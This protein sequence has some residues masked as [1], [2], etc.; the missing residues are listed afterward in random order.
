MKVFISWSG[1]RSKIIADVLRDW[2]PNVIQNVNPWTSSSDIDAG[3]RWP[4][5]LAEQLQQTNLGII[6]LTAENLKAPWILFEA[7]AL[8]KIMDK[9]KVCP[10]L[11]ALEPTEV[12]GPLAQFQAVKANKEGTKKLLQT[13]N[14]LQ[15]ES[16]LPEDRLNKSFEAFWPKLEEVLLEV[17]KDHEQ[18]DLVVMNREDS[19]LLKYLKESR[20]QYIHLE[21]RMATLGRQAKVE[22]NEEILKDMSISGSNLLDRIEQEK[23]VLSI[24]TSK[25]MGNTHPVIESRKSEY[26]H[27]LRLLRT[28][29][30]NLMI[31]QYRNRDEESRKYEIARGDALAARDLLSNALETALL[32]R[33]QRAIDDMVLR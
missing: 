28:A 32:Q 19:E 11:F 26:L 12:T 2:L 13:I 7:G 22:W 14:R 18:R 33:S 16:A 10:Y 1:S 5:A 24:Y 4:L 21:A 30:R 23:D 29:T 15:N 25:V 9:T 20:I 8:S 6:C 17:P 27:N 3:T 31:P